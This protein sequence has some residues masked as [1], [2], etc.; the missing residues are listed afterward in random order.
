MTNSISSRGNSGEMSVS[1]ETRI[2]KLND[3]GRQFN[4]PPV[5]T[6]GFCN[7]DAFMWGMNKRNGSEKYF[8]DMNDLV[9]RPEVDMVSLE[10]KN[11]EYNSHFK[12]KTLSSLNI[13]TQNDLIS[14][15]T[16]YLEILTYYENIMVTYRPEL[17][18]SSYR[19]SDWAKVYNEI[20]GIKE[21]DDNA[22]IKEASFSMVVNK[23]T[24]VD[25]LK[26]IIPPN[27]I[28]MMS[29][30]G[31][32]T[33]LY[34]DGT[35][36]SYYDP[37]VGKPLSSSQ[38]ENLLDALDRGLENSKNKGET[39]GL[40]FS[41]LDY[42]KFSLPADYYM[43]FKK[44]LFSENKE[45]LHGTATALHFALMVGDMDILEIASQTPGYNMDY[46]LPF[47]VSQKHDFFYKLLDMVK[48]VNVKDSKG[49]SALEHAVNYKDFKMINAL[50][51]KDATINPNLL[52]YLVNNE[53]E[54]LRNLLAH[55]I[56]DINALLPSIDATA[57][58]MAS[59]K[60]NTQLE[61]LLISKGADVNKKNKDGNSYIETLIVQGRV[62][63]LEALLD[64]KLVNVNITNNYGKSI[65]ATCI[66][67]NNTAIAIELLKQGADPDAKILSGLNSIFH[68]SC[69]HNEPDLIQFFLK[70]GKNG[71]ELNLDLKT[72][73]EIAAEKGHIGIVNRFLD[74]LPS[75]DVRDEYDRPLIGLAIEN[76]NILL[77]KILLQRG[78]NLDVKDDSGNL[79]M[80]MAKRFNNPEIMKLL[81]EHQKEK[82][83]KESIPTVFSPL[84]NMTSLKQS[85][86]EEQKNQKDEMGIDSEEAKKIKKGP[87]T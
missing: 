51:E 24:L 55:K 67:T 70:S 65:L 13:E 62:D 28:I 84:Y 36:Y 30:I 42:A 71:M 54:S 38:L 15:H 68:W 44:T 79:I 22:L 83:D 21:N 86:K 45:K 59:L 34:Y 19:Q 1:Q 58:Y 20:Q 74:N 85:K 6:G 35:N 73:I 75:V 33:A 49:I 76:N 47:A 5:A 80:D 11:I 52:G 39:I 4:R 16:Q 18:F 32:A 14:A 50:F 61:D 66:E 48:D 40:G 7:G 81:V 77:V 3:W 56:E 17:A 78:V 69:E 8:L 23:N 12:N 64:K 60:Q 26:K 27:K 25:T 31:H 63:R 53:S 29:S 9:S 82:Q 2:N 10:R 41:I 87:I 57:L 37:N 46:I 72:A 43:S